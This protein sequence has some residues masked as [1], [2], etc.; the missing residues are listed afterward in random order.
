MMPDREESRS[1]TTDKEGS[2]SAGKASPVID[3]Q[4]GASQSESPNPTPIL[5]YGVRQ[6]GSWGPKYAEH[7]RAPKSRIRKQE[8]TLGDFRAP[9]YDY[10]G[11]RHAQY[12]VDWLNR[13]PVA[14]RVGTVRLS[15]QRVLGLMQWLIPLSTDPF[16]GQKQALNTVTLR[17]GR[18]PFY[19]ERQA[20]DAV[21]QL[22]SQ[23]LLHQVRR[24]Q[25]CGRWFYQIRTS[26]Y[27]S[28]ATRPAGRKNTHRRRPRYPL[29][30]RRR[31]APRDRRVEDVEHRPY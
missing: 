23:G 24:C 15:Q 16:H 1:T 8:A 10:Q 17:L 3:A 5:T 27:R 19:G 30:L 14:S 21:I 20:V 18:K 13:P 31:E 22:A 26:E 12:L 11:L 6:D 9:R 2:E 7:S 28:C 25:N 29:A 4:A